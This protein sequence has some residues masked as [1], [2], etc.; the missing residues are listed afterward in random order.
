M[1]NLF[2]LLALVLVLTSC[3][4][5]DVPP[6]EPKPSYRCEQMTLENK[7]EGCKVGDWWNFDLERCNSTEEKC[8]K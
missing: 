7:V 3:G 6:T 4:P 5:K 1:K 2:S 8:M